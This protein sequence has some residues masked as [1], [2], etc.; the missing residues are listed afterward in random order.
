MLSDKMCDMYR[1]LPLSILVFKNKELVHINKYL[2][3][4]FC[5]DELIIEL[6]EIKTE[7]YYHIFEHAY[8]VKIT[9]DKMLFEQLLKLEALNYKQQNI[10][11]DLFE[12]EEHTVFILTLIKSKESSKLVNLTENLS[13]ETKIYDIFSKTQ[14]R[15]FRLFSMYK[16]LHINSDALLI[17]V[18]DEHLVFKVS[19]KHLCS[20]K[21]NN[22]F[23]ITPHINSKNAIISKATKVDISKQ[24]LYLSHLQNRPLSAKNR[25][26]IRV[27]PHNESINIRIHQELFSLYDISLFSL[28]FLVSKNN[29]LFNKEK[30]VY[31]LSFTLKDDTTMVA[32]SIQAQVE[33]IMSH[34]KERKIVLSFLENENARQKIKHYINFRQMELLRELKDVVDRIELS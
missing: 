11:I 15:S 9:N 17:E 21:D 5:I 4:M 30:E 19:K 6:K 20:F 28:S 34:D 7:I 29:A 32:I 1:K 2:L 10:Q 27:K 24:L 13:N 26:T 25:R 8:G 14:K 3:E 16:G 22:E 33:K 31:D 23:I 18:D 12:E